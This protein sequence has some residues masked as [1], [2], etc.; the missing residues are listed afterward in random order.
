MKTNCVTTMAIVFLMISTTVV[1]AQ[2]TQTKLNQVELMKQFIGS[3]KGDI[4]KDT[5]YYWDVKSY[6]TGLEC[7]MKIVTKGKT[8]SEGKQLWGYD[9]KLDK[10]IATELSKGMDMVVYVIQ[11]IS[12]SKEEGFSYDFSHPEKVPN[13]WAAEFKSPDM[14][15]ETTFLNNISVKT[16]TYTRIK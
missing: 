11:F 4:G 6:G 5:T 8:I 15:E 13:K 7:T 3:W 10:C 1:Q 14:F 2:T 12:K 9:K 16:D